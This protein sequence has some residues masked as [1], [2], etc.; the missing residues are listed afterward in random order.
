MQNFIPL[1]IAMAFSITGCGPDVAS[2]PTD[3]SAMQS[4]IDQHPEMNI[5]DEQLNSQ[6]EPGSAKM[7]G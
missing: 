4:Y 3:S 7:E 2:V 5:T 6:P 1:A